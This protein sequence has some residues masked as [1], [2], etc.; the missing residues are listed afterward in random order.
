MVRSSASLLVLGAIALAGPA[1][2]PKAV[3]SSK[4]PLVVASA[5]ARDVEL[6]SVSS[7]VESMSEAVVVVVS[8]TRVTLAGDR[9]PI[10][11]VP[12]DAALGLS[13]E[14]KRDGRRDLYVT[15]LA[16]A[17]QGAIDE[18]RRDGGAVESAGTAGHA[19]RLQQQI[20]LALHP[21]AWAALVADR[22]TPYRVL[23][24]VVHTIDAVQSGGVCIAV[25]GNNGIGC[26]FVRAAEGE[27]SPS[28]AKHRAPRP[29]TRE[30][31]RGMELVVVLEADGYDLWMR[32]AHIAP[33]CADRGGGRTVPGRE[34]HGDLT[35]CATKLK[36]LSPEFADADS[37]A[38]AASE[39]TELHE[40]T[41]AIAA[42][43]STAAGQPLLP[44]AT[45]VLPEMP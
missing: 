8:R 37:F 42:L 5:A 38:L 6:A 26:A 4:D 12:G 27:R 13:A 32:G 19:E 36:G 20:L 30:S 44:E 23:L 31:A 24:E 34:H 2:K 17:L 21:P 28:L 45:L 18:R 16:L 1:C 14:D 3:A 39:T 7:K 15:P 33:G 41:E 43:A 9:Y 10:A 35:T 40:I 22:H 25:R 11:E 29:G